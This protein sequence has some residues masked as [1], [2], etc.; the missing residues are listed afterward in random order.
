MDI[1]FVVSYG[2][3]RLVIVVL[4]EYDVLDGLF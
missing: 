4:G 2:E 1:V 3:G